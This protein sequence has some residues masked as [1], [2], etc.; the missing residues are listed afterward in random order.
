MSEHFCEVNTDRW[1][2]SPYEPRYK[3]CDKAARFYLGGTWMCADCYDAADRE[4]ATDD[5]LDD[6]EGLR[7]L[8][9]RA[10]RST[11]KRTNVWPCHSTPPV[12]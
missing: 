12:N 5:D 10:A 2:T 11:R 8:N 6:I 1:A 4:L 3:P 9:L 7:S